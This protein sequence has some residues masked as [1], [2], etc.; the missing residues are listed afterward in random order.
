M[1]R[2]EGDKSAILK[3]GEFYTLKDL[4]LTMLVSSTNVSAISLATDISGSPENFIHKMNDWAKQK[5]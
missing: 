2:N 3:E 4:L 5:I 1:L